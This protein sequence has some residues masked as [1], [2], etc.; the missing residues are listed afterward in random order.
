M[1]PGMP[2]AA[3]KLRSV[4]KKLLDI[5]SL[6]RHNPRMPT[7]SLSHIRRGLAWVAIAAI[8]LRVWAPPA[9]E[10]QTYALD[11]GTAENSVGL[12][13][14]VGG[15][16]VALN[17]FAVTGGNNTITSISIAW[18]DATAPDP[19]LNGLPYTVG[20]WSDPNGDGAPADAALLASADGVILAAGTNTFIPT[21]I[22]PTAVMTPNFFVGFIITHPADQNPAAFD[23]TA[24]S[25]PNRSFIVF[26]GDINDLSAAAPIENF[27]GPGNWL[28]RAEAIPEAST[29]ALVGLGLAGLVFFRNRR[30]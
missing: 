6:H 20:L 11:D 13:G 3:V 27:V 1:G 14:A 17:S 10:A 21:V 25:F 4:R 2:T 19:F 5:Q 30:T 7:G 9:A 16:F 23:Q 26:P 28:I 24:P 18:G 12:S 15:T 8:T 29:F 22:T